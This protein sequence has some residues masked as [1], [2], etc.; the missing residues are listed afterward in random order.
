M[1]S[2]L[3]A[4]TTDTFLDLVSWL[5]AGEMEHE[6]TK[7]LL[8]KASFLQL[9][10]KRYGNLAQLEKL[11]SFVEDNV[12]IA[13]D[14]W[15]LMYN[16]ALDFT[17]SYFHPVKKYTAKLSMLP[18]IQKDPSAESFYNLKTALAMNLFSID[19]LA[20][21]KNIYTKQI[22][23]HVYSSDINPETVFIQTPF[24]KTFTLSKLNEAEHVF[25]KYTAGLSVKFL[26]IDN[27][28]I[29]GGSLFIS[30]FLEDD[31][32]DYPETDIDIFVWGD[33]EQSRLDTINKIIKEIDALTSG[34]IIVT[35][36]GMVITIFRRGDY[37]P[38]QIID[39]GTKKCE[40][41]IREFDMESSKIFYTKGEF[42][43]SSQF[44]HAINTKCDNIK[45]CKPERVAK[46]MKRGFN[47]TAS[48]SQKIEGS[49]CF[50]KDYSWDKLYEKPEVI[51]MLNKYFPITNESPERVEFLAQKLFSK[52]YKLVSAPLTISDIIQN[53]NTTALCNYINS[54]NKI[55]VAENANDFLNMVSKFK[56]DFIGGHECRVR[57]ARDESN[58]K[59]FIKVKNLRGTL[60]RG[61]NAY[62]VNA[63]CKELNFLTSKLA[64]SKFNDI[65]RHKSEPQPSL[66][67]NRITITEKDK[68]KTLIDEYPSCS[69]INLENAIL[70]VYQIND[71]IRFKVKFIQ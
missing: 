49:D 66:L 10:L 41:I 6:Q 64:I 61:H 7:A 37:L 28:M 67:V 42:K 35:T 17:N 29:A 3:K 59:L 69:E 46:Y 58:K 21:T 33:T 34:K 1:Q 8:E 16:E 14:S 22:T 56:G 23:S 11:Y 53:G 68:L 15:L 63:T 30:L 32:N 45:K 51:S 52:K 70:S 50:V 24:E 9:Y 25:S 31:L 26:D 47:I 57:Y 48:T 36:C 38:I 4:Y 20:K 71:L 44:I 5:E 65:R 60:K 39:S 43:V 27:A 55:T 13:E 19:D 62:I 54:D 18:L 2:Q 12:E 40:D